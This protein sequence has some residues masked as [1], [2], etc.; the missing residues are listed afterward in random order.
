MAAELF[1]QVGA[2]FDGIVDIE[3]LDGT[4]GAGDDIVAGLGQDDRGAVE[5]FRQAR[6]NDTDDAFVPV[7]AKEQGRL[8]LG[9]WASPSMI[10]IA[11]WVIL[12]SR[13]SAPYCDR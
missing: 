11:S 12:T 5:F 6:S 9:E 3:I 10:S 7:G 2:G 4:G 1:E 8:P 13:F